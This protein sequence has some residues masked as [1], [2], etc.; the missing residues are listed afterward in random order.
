LLEIP[1]ER[2][3]KASNPAT[4]IQG[5]TPAEGNTE[6]GNTSNEVFDLVVAGRKEGLHIP[7]V[8]SRSRARQYSPERIRRSE[9]VPVVLGSLDIYEYPTLREAAESLAL[10][11]WKEAGEGILGGYDTGMF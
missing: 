9:M 5:T 10:A 3:R 1:G 2:K 6:V 11:L 4:K 7:S 8:S